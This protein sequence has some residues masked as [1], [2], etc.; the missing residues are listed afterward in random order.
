M[1]SANLWFLDEALQKEKAYWLEKL[2]GQ[3]T[4]SGLPRDFVRLNSGGETRAIAP[5]TLRP[6][7]E[8]LLFKLCG[9]QD[10]LILAAL[11]S[12][13]KVCLRKYTGAEDI[14]IGTTI[15]E[16][17]RESSEFNSLLALR[18]RVYDAMPVRQLLLDVKDTLA[19]AYANQKYPF[20]RILE[21]TG[22]E[23]SPNRFPLFSVA[24]LYENINNPEHVRR[25]NNDASLIFS[26][27][28]ESPEGRIEYLPS[29]FSED[30]IE[31]FGDHFAELLY[32]ILENPE[33][34]VE[35]L[36]LLTPEKRERLLVD[37]NRTGQEYP[38]GRGIHELFERQVERTPGR[39]A[40]VSGPRS[41]TYSELNRRANRL[42]KLLCERNCVRGE[43]IGVCLSHSPETL[44]AI[45]GVLKAGCAYVPLEPD[46]PSKRLSFILRDAGIRLILTEEGIAEK[47]AD[48]E[49]ET[50]LL[51]DQWPG[52]IDTA[53]GNPQPIGAASD[54]AYV[55][56]TSGS[57]GEP[58]GVRVTHSSL[59]NYICWAGQ[60]Y[61]QGKESAF[62]LYSSLA[63]DLTVTSIFTPLVTGNLVVIYRQDG[64]E[65]PVKDILQGGLVDILKLTPSHLSLIKDN[66]NSRSR[67]SV[68]IVGGEAFES[69]LARAV[70]E[71]FGGSVAIYNEYGPTEAT[72]GCMTHKYDQSVDQRAQVP[73]GR[74]AANTEIYLLDDRRQPVAENVIGEL[75]IAGACLADGYL[76]RDELTK[77][78]FI[79][80]P[81]RPGS[82][83][84]RTGDLAR[85]TASGALEFLGRK[86]EQV[87]FHGY[88]IE[89]NEIRSA[90]NRHP[91]VRDGAVLVQK[92]RNGQ[93]V[94]MAYYVS[95]HELD[96]AKL[97]EF[98]AESLIEETIPNL[99]VHLKR[100]PLTLNGKINHAGLPTVEE[101]R[102]LIKRNY[103]APASE[104]EKMVA[105]SW[106]KVLGVEQVGVED[107]FFELGGHSLLATQIISRLR[108]VCGVELPLRSLFERPTVGGLAE[109]LEQTLR[110]QE[111]AGRPAIRKISRTAE[112]PLSFSQQR[113]WFLDQLEPG[114]PAYNMPE[115]V[116]LQGK[117][118]LEVLKRSLTE[119]VRRHESLRTAFRESEGRPVQVIIP[120]GPVVPELIDLSG[121]PE[122]ERY[123]KLSR[124]I[125]EEADRPFD[126]QSGAPLRVAVWRC[127]EDDHILMF[128]MHH[129]VSDGWSLAIFSQ[130]LTVLYEA[131]SQG[132]TSPLPDLE[133]QYADYSYWQRQWLQGEVLDEH[134][135]YWRS[136]LEGTP[137]LNLSTCRSRPSI[138][139]FKGATESFRASRSLSALVKDLRRKEEV[140][141]FIALL[142]A[143]KALL[144]RYTGQD[145]I[146]VGSFIAG[147][148]QAETEKIIGFFINNLAFR[149]DLSGA[150]TFR[151]LIRRTRETAL[152]AYAHQELPFEKLLEELQPE[153][154]LSRTPLFQVMLVVQ[155]APERDL[156]IPGVEVSKVSAGG[157]RSNFDLTLWLWES[158]DELAGSATYNCDLFDPGFIRQMLNHFQVLLEA[159]CAE[160]ELRI[161]DLPIMSAAERD[162]ILKEWSRGERARTGDQCLHH[163][164]ERQAQEN[165]HRIAIAD[166]ARRISY[167]D[168]NRRSNQVAHWLIEKGA[169]PER[170]VMLCMRRS[171][172][173][174]IG[175]LGALKAG[176]A[177]AP[178]DP[179][180]AAGR[181]NFVLRDSRIK[182]ALTQEQLDI[183]LPA[184]VEK[185]CLDTQWPELN[186]RGDENPEIPL[187]AGNAAYVIYTS[188]STGE[189]KGVLIE[190]RSAVAY[191][192]TAAA[193]YEIGAGDRAL[194][195]A[196]L[197]FDAAVEEIFPTLRAG[198]EL[199]LRGEGM[200]DSA[201]D[202]IRRT[203]EEGITI[204]NLPTAYWHLLVSEMEELELEIPGSLRLVIIGGEKA[205]T[206]R[207]RE[208][209]LKIGD[210]VKLV[211][212]YGP[213]E[214][215]V[216]ATSWTVGPEVEMWRETPI[217]RPV[218]GVNVYIMDRAGNIAAQKTPGELRLGGVGLARA[219]LNNA[220][221]TGEKFTPDPYGA[222]PGARIYR[223]GDYG[224][225][226][227]GGEIEFVGRADQQVK[228]RGFR[229]E[230]GEIE[231]VIVK[232]PEVRE[233]AV[234]A[235]PMANGELGLCAYVVPVQPDGLEPSNLR[236]F[237]REIIPGY[238]IPASITMIASL[239]RTTSGKIAREALPD[240]DPG[241]RREA[242]GYVA[243]RYTEEE[244]LAGIWSEL[245]GVAEVGV[246]DNFFAL[247]GHSILATQLISRMRR[248]F[249]VE[250]ALRSL[251]EAPTIAEMALVIEDLLID[252]LES[253]EDD[254]T[255]DKVEYEIAH[256]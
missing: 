44:V 97:R 152:G 42:A 256:V 30:T 113:L 218:R 106:G 178:L 230:P 89:L 220:E 61:L 72:V 28:G 67:V 246:Y 181:L 149:T 34:R 143:F 243:P 99:F 127:A 22:A 137:A 164:I 57:T 186:R 202:F 179:E 105:E 135:E 199:A 174:I 141:L 1:T 140:T 219:Y 86:D 237:L 133:A 171:P 92:D 156:R 148:D 53:E 123:L 150:P 73:I 159:G 161:T 90:L 63:F 165:P 18:D 147:R 233:T 142:A 134:L 162:H 167:A 225:F 121:L 226:L 193:A 77:E 144:S 228:I 185:L 122:D 2:S 212:T 169:G 100:I 109:L 215:T 239:P 96:V 227:A 33:R 247:G 198:A 87:K 182:F 151:E 75:Y 82:G 4:Y 190:H 128:T 139:S 110:S 13:L 47:F 46:Y 249:Q 88:R 10:I 84:Y 98:L 170:I 126:L 85:W 217:G 117:F 27:R 251:F 62:A 124:Q 204:W 238:M 191:T 6:G 203:E 66:D 253:L 41:L 175:L 157:G 235:R 60:T 26:S 104:A 102:K 222:E 118:D 216:V 206:E 210:R 145:D 155:N 43:L 177:Y 80:N 14:I 59:V 195:F 136:R 114:T 48:E 69:E 166:G 242:G 79:D 94:L 103:V 29:L 93:S 211:N 183:D 236:E 176:A 184:G 189:P 51:S 83:M 78:R 95:R 194:Q 180:M 187:D 25:I 163:L 221:M 231:S 188:G 119:I 209:R 115:T 49:V 229:V 58:K 56:Y 168:L 205:L 39:T 32:R 11:V 255:M 17:Y 68:L 173:M 52:L 241:E 213:T 15:H 240:P 248:A 91:Q 125:R 131:F 197:A 129:I 172:E 107:N 24:A 81:F 207:V 31:I 132:A 244:I 234:V 54:L 232:H 65:S 138:Q 208:W 116:R 71:S 111:R 200:L 36:S 3:L 64:R 40:V 23:R 19:Q 224:R 245:L 112:L 146:C 108:S 120:P 196:S 5:I 38:R 9:N 74:P 154:D 21:L 192:E 130:E 250:V 254:A 76:N 160:P 16:N 7:T 37:F 55:I 8:R 12:A 101:A 201:E 214:A 223:T 50:T 153:R 158:G 35:D 20:D 252:Q 70:T 45:L